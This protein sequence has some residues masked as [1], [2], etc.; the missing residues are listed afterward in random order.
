MSELEN[1][2]AQREK[3]RD[4]LNFFNEFLDSYEANPNLVQLQ[5]RFSQITSSFSNYN[6]LY[7]DI[8][9]LDQSREQFNMRFELQEKYITA[10]DK[11]EKF[12]EKDKSKDNAVILQQNLQ[13]NSS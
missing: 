2:I 10:I 12:W 3:L 13:N 4:Q 8:F 5:L 7:D 6:K 1:L 11:A 9:E